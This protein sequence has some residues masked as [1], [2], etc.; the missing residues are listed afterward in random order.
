VNKGL[1]LA[2]C[3]GIIIGVSGC[4][5]EATETVDSAQSAVDVAEGCSPSG[6]EVEAI[7]ISGAFGD[8]PVVTFDAPLTVEATQRVVVIEGSGDEVAVG[9][10]LIIDYSLYNAT[11][12]AQIDDSGYDELSPTPFPLDPSNPVLTGL[13][14]TLACSTVGSRVAGLIP[15]VE[16]FGPDGAPELGMQP[17][18]GLLFIADVISIKPPPVPPLEGLEG[19]PAEPGE[20]FPSVSYDDA[21]APVVVIPE[22]DVP[23]EF[24]LETL[25]TGEGAVVASADVVIVEYHGVNWNTGLVFD[26][27]WER[28]QPGIFPAGRV[29][30]GFRDALLGQTVGSRVIVVIPAALGYGPI[31]GTEDGKIGAEDTIVFV[32]DI[33]GVQ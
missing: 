20:G 17:G 13:S 7:D 3:A 19:E 6:S 26:S 8:S 4:A 1:V 33:L 30:A 2:L 23:T 5:P 12:G 32:V 18:D 29:I 24:A 15:A 22:G 31:G 9:D 14:L 11:S 16:A 10:D 21:G 27:S 25:I 28:G